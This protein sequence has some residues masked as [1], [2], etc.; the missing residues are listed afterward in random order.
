MSLELLTDTMKRAESVSGS[1]E[2]QKLFCDY[3]E[4]TD[5]SV[6]AD[7][8]HFAS[9]KLAADYLGIEM[10]TGP[11]L[12]DSLKYKSCKKSCQSVKDLTQVMRQVANTSGKDTVSR[13]KSLL[14]NVLS[15]CTDVEAEY[16]KR[17]ALGK[18]RIGITEKALMQCVPGVSKSAVKDLYNKVPDIEKLLQLISSGEYLTKKNF[19][20]AGVPVKPMLASPCKSVDDLRKRFKDGDFIAEYKY[21]GERAQVHK[22]RNGKI[23]IFSRNSENITEKYPDVTSRV[24]D[25]AVSYILDC[26]IVACD[27]DYKILPFQSLQKRKRKDVTTENISVQ[28][29][30]FVFD[31]LLLNDESLLSESYESRRKTLQDVIPVVPGKLELATV[32]RPTFDNLLECVQTSVDDRCEGLMIK[33]LKEKYDPSKRSLA[34]FK[35]KKDYLDTLGGDTLD[36][37]VVGGYFGKGK[38]K[39][40]FGGFLLATFDKTLEEFQSVCNI[41]TGFTDAVLSKFYNDLKRLA[42][43]KPENYNTTQTPDVWFEPVKVIEVRAADFTMSL[44]HTAATNGS[45]GISL[46]FPRMVRE[47]PDKKIDQLTDPVQI[48]EMYKSQKSVD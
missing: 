10:G 8:I 27:K 32:K 19:L 43:E 25:C 39:G 35:L 1:L 3:F 30:V 37:V 41:G 40:V 20:F 16:V 13:K 2:K 5:P 6:W 12:V 44:D 46:R 14:E 31:I 42:I 22:E 26:E 9:G 28:V 24:P 11:S 36:L 33:S 47:R 18:M 34:W 48:L 38:R 4:K 7:A 21:D 23:S 45:Q 17:F 29:V 15:K